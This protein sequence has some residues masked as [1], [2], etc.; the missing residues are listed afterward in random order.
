MR[1]RQWKRPT[2][3]RVEFSRSAL[4]PTDQKVNDWPI[5]VWLLWSDRLWLAVDDRHVRRDAAPHQHQLDSTQARIRS[6]RSSIWTARATGHFT[7]A[8][9]NAGARWPTP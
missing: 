1:F 3:E 4:Q 5:R 2:V 7:F 9:W 6:G 8:R